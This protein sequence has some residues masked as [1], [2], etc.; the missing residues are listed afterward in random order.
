MRSS[1]E[2]FHP[3]L[4]GK[5]WLVV[6]GRGGVL[7]AFE[8]LFC[9][10]ERSAE[11]ASTPAET[12]PTPPN[13]LPSFLETPELKQMH[14]GR[15]A[16][17]QATGKAGGPS[18]RRRSAFSVL[19]ASSTNSVP[20]WKVP[21]FGRTSG[22]KWQVYLSSAGPTSR[23]S[24]HGMSVRCFD[25]PSGGPCRDVHGVGIDIVELGAAVLHCPVTRMRRSAERN[26]RGNER[27]RRDLGQ[28]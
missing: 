9:R 5:R 25:R 14:G 24:S 12:C 4:A 10:V 18:F 13:T 11:R 21:R 15:P 20:R 27:S 2:L 1:M 26:R 19:T 6:E 22:R 17:A 3:R 7:G 28:L 16:S 23:T 8:A